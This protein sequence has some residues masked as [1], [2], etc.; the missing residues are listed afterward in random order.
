[1]KLNALFWVLTSFFQLALAVMAVLLARKF[2]RLDKG[3]F[4]RLGLFYAWKALVS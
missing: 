3:K 2:R 1:M 4:Y